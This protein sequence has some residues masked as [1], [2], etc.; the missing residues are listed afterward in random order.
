MT[1]VVNLLVAAAPLL[2]T[3]AHA[4]LLTSFMAALQNLSLYKNTSEFYEKYLCMGS[5]ASSLLLGEPTD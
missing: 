4:V 5:Q 3:T 1:G 2:K